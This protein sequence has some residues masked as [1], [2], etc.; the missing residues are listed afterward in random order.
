MI[1]SGQKLKET[2]RRNFLKGITATPAVALAT[3]SSLLAQAFNNPKTESAPASGQSSK[4]PGVFVGMQIG[5]RSFV[6]EG[7]EKCLDTLQETVAS[8][9]SL[10]LCLL[11]EQG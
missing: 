2:S 11:M 4:K 3:G 10:R 5:A 1:G 8:M 7:V 9:C 6:D